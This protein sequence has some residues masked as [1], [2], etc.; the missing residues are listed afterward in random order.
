MFEGCRRGAACWIAAGG[1]W[2]AACAEVE[3]RPGMAG[4]CNDQACIDARGNAIPLPLPTGSAGAAGAAGSGNMPAAGAEV[5]GTVLEIVTQ[6]LVTSQ[7]LRGDVEVR[8]ESAGGGDVLSAEPAGDGTYR[9]GGLALGAVWV[10]VGNFRDPPVEPF[11]DT[12]Q[13]VDTSLA[14]FT[15]LV[16]LRRDVLV[17]L[18]AT[19]FINSPVDFDPDSAHIVVQF[20][21]TDRQPVEGVQITFPTPESVSTAYDAGDLYSD[22]LASTSTRGMAVLLNVGGA[23]PFPGSLTSIVADLDGEQLTASVQIARGAVSVV[24]AVVPDP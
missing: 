20:V 12:L 7:S 11:I 8:A 19:S 15:N 2:V 4:D 17:E 23:A 16:V 13:A 3:P 18:A 21:D 5:S 6:D 10:G 9:L 1:V 22:A 14:G 24:T